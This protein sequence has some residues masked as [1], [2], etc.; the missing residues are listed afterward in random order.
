MSEFKTSQEKRLAKENSLLE[1]GKC[2]LC[3]SII[4]LEKSQIKDFYEAMIDRTIQNLTIVEVLNSWGITS[5]ITNISTHRN[6]LQGDPRH[7]L[8]LKKAAGL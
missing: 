3:L 2:K 1:G 8:A 6:S 7:L 4:G 5:S